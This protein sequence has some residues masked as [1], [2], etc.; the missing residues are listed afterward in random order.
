MMILFSCNEHLPD[1]K[2]ESKNS[3]V[4]IKTETKK[5]Q[6]NSLVENNKIIGYWFIPHS[7]RVNIL[8][9]PNK[10]FK[11]ND[12]NSVEDKYEQL[13]GIYELIDTTTLLLNYS[14]R[15]KQHFKFNKGAD[16][17]YYITKKGYYFVKG[18]SLL[19]N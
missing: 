14:D 11:F 4:D 15:P 6:T 10:H 8:F 7:A 9:L 1:K 3:E 19:T 12:Y 17:N 5:L 18:D 16:D 2:K 13:T